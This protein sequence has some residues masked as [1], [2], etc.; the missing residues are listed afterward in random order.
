MRKFGL[1]QDKKELAVITVKKNLE[2][3]DRTE[4]VVMRIVEDSGLKS[5]KTQKFVQ[6]TNDLDMDSNGMRQV[7]EK[8]PRIWFGIYLV[9]FTNIWNVE[10][11]APD[12]I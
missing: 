5:H 11:V 6:H 1:E 10:I 2:L 4:V 3:K 8:L 12:K 9:P 7:K